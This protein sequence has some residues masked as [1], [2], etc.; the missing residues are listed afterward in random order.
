[1]LRL[2]IQ[3]NVSMFELYKKNTAVLLL[4]FYI[5]EMQRFTM[6]SY[7]NKYPIFRPDENA[8]GKLL[9]ATVNPY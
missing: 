6:I 4:Y 7:L 2:D 3:K 8:M 1:M 5:V 9:S